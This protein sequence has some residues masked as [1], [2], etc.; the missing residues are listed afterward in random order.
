MFIGS[1][2]FLCLSLSLTLQ[3]AGF[4]SIV[5]G[6]FLAASSDTAYHTVEALTATG[7]ANMIP[8]VAGF[9]YAKKGK[10]VPASILLALALAVELFEVRARTCLSVTACLRGRLCPYASA[11][12]FWCV[13]ARYLHIHHAFWLLR[14]CITIS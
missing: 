9:R 12:V 1:S 8:A 3:W 7:V 10:L 4:V 13:Q 5:W 14:S 2:L 11:V 6:I